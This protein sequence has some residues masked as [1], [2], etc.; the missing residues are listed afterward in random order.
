MK[1]IN[2]ESVK[3]IAEMVGGAVSY[4][5]VIAAYGKFMECMTEIPESKIARYDDAVGAIMKS[6][7]YSHDKSHAVAAL[8]RNGCSDFYRAIIHIAKDS[9]MYSHDKVDM[10]KQLSQD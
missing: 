10:I 9:S 5:L 2:W 7:M 1:K 4:V 3:G 8:K 6:S